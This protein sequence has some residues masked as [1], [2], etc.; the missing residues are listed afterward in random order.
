MRHIGETAGLDFDAVGTRVTSLQDDLTGSARKPLLLLLGASCLLLLTACTNLASTLL[1]RGTARGPEL[2]VRTAIGAGR[3]RLVRQIFTESIVIAVAGCAV[4]LVL[5][6]GLLRG[7]AALAPPSLRLV[8]DVHLDVRVLGFTAAVAL[9]TAVLFGFLPALRLTSI[10]SSMLVKGG[11]RGGSARRGSI[12]SV[13]V[14]SQVALAV[15]L[16]IGSG[17][18]LRSFARITN[19]NLGFNP[20]HVLTAAIDLP[21]QNYPQVDRAVQFHDRMLDAVRAIPGVQAA[22]VTNV[23]PT[24]GVG[25]DGGMEVEGKPALSP[26]HPGTGYATY[27]LASTGYF[28]AMQMRVVQ[29]R[30]FL[31]SDRASSPLV[32][33]V[34]R[35]LADKEWPGESPLGKRMRP[36]GMDAELQQWA[37]VVGVVDN[38]PGW[39]AIGPSPE[40]YYYS[41]RQL[42]VRTRSM[43]AVVRS[44]RPTGALIQAVRGAI[45]RV[46][47]QAPVEFRTMSDFVTAS[48]SDRRFMT[49]LLGLFAVI[50][51]SLAAV[52]IYGAVAYSVAQRTRE[53]GIRIALGAVPSSVGWKVQLS[54]MST[55]LV[56]TA[57]GVVGALA[58]THLLQSNA[59]RRDTDRPARLRRRGG[60]AGGDGVAR[61]LG[62]GPAWYANRS[63]EGDPGGVVD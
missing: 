61:E 14:V 32:V 52:G 57:I 62:A 35:D 1:A 43:T 3:L 54:A 15:V 34:N 7:V 56:G 8:R 58:G 17:L 31:E 29:G 45:A 2:A 4:G 19:V 41:Y 59:L 22:G 24:D 37:T 18:L 33:I 25:P 30:D 40:T 20:D 5:A 21:E 27:R 48:V 50:A 13:L 55:V 6:E 51:L 36:S 47:P 38:V 9:I 11:S 49:I 53:I 44:S 12:W 23:L 16:L 42:P 63:T 60:A 39:T 10:S 46:D 26:A 28:P